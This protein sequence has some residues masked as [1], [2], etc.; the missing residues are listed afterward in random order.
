ML[1]AMF[2]MAFL[3]LPRLH[4]DS[5]ILNQKKESLGSPVKCIFIIFSG[6]ENQPIDC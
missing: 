6:Y 2:Y 1:K 5:I 3:V 4:K